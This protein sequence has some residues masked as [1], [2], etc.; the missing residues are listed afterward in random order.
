SARW[1]TSGKAI[2]YLLDEGSLNSLVE[3]AVSGGGR[4][5]GSAARVIQRGMPQLFNWFSS[6]RDE[7][8]ALGE[9][10]TIDN[11]ESFDLRAANGHPRRIAVAPGSY[12]N[13][14][15]LSPDGKRV[16]LGTGDY[17]GW[18]AF[19]IPTDGGDMSALT[20]A[21]AP[22]AEHA[23]GW[24]NDG[25]RVVLLSTQNR[26]SMLSL[27]DV[28]TG[29]MRALDQANAV[30]IVGLGQTAFEVAGGQVA[31]ISKGVLSRIDT[32]AGKS[33]VIAKIDGELRRVSP[34]GR[35]IAVFGN[36]P[37]E[38]P[39]S[40]VDVETGKITRIAVLPRPF[41]AVIG[42]GRDGSL[43]LPKRTDAGFE[44]WRMPETGGTPVKFATVPGR[45]WPYGTDLAVEAKRAVCYSTDVYPDIW[46]L[47]PPG[48]VAKK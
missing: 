42:W 6:S 21:Q 20:H 1:A 18:N 39:L 26:R 19:V 35:R 43:Y 13:T 16:A 23:V 2:L 30:A 36:E 10:Y 33:T 7:R 41:G 47:E 22:A 14:P 37:V 34:D 11:L 38:A 9:V 3:R 45:C 29:R 44:I 4:K 32:I 48:A 8:L 12:F 15:Y 17:Q 40:I 27:L 5:F 46:M 25:R 31:Y 24:M 28:N